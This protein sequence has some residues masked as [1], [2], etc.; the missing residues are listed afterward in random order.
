MAARGRL[1]LWSGVVAVPETIMHPLLEL[2]ADGQEHTVASLR[3]QLAEYFELSPEERA[4]RLTSGR[5]TRF[6]NRV[7]WAS[8][9]LV[10]TGLLERPRRGVTRIRPRG[11][12]ILEREPERIDLQVLSQFPELHAFRAG[13]ALDDTPPV[14]PEEAAETPSAT[15]D[16]VMETAY[17]QL[18]SALAE[19]LLDRVKDQTPTFFEHLVL[20]VLHSMGYGGRRR[21]GTERLGRTGDEG[22]DGVIREDKL[23]LDVIYVQAKR[24]QNPVGRPVIQ[25]F[26]GALQGARASKGVLITTSTFTNDAQSYAANVSPRVILVDGRE[27]AELMLDHDVGVS[28]STRYEIKRIDEDYFV[29]DAD[30]SAPSTAE[31][32]GEA[33]EAEASGP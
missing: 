17:E 3:G 23:G 26:V 13:Q 30:G 27:L 20:D 4:E 29:E 19:E 25:G 2:H 28:S 12:E 9:Y 21:A 11:S 24:W 22:L 5:Q 16:E 33:A 18:R 1:D 7:G 14:E 15:P 32:P 31:G 8:T 10:K 6:A